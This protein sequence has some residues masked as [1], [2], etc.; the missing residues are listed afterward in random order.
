M[1]DNLAKVPVHLDQTP[2]P[3]SVTYVGW[4]SRGIIRWNEHRNRESLATPI[5]PILCHFSIYL[6]PDCPCFHKT[7]AKAP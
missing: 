2:L 6:R 5:A 3:W 7:I 1:T 4:T